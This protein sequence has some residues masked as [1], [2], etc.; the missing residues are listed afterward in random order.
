[1]SSFSLEEHVAQI[2]MILRSVDGDLADQ[3]RVTLGLQRVISY[4]RSAERQQCRIGDWLYGAN[5]DPSRASRFPLDEGAA[6]CEAH[7]FFIC[8]DS[9]HKVLQNL[10]SNVYG[11]TAARTVLKRFRRDLDRYTDARDHLEHLPERF[12]GGR[13]GDWIGDANSITGSI[14]GIRRDGYFVFQGQSWDVSTECIRLLT[15]LVTQFVISMRVEA[16]ETLE[17]F[18]RGESAMRSSIDR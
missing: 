15:Q 12:P 18:R 1:M 10:R 16:D 13:R 8:W 7:F 6:L 5:D 14:A 4:L 3:T 2:E 11:F 9:I 17:R